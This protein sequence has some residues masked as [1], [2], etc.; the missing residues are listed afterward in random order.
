LKILG[1]V[2][3]VALI[4]SL[5]LANEATSVTAILSKSEVTVGEVFTIEL[6]ATGPEGTVWTFPETASNETVEVRPPVPD[7][8]A[9]SPASSPLPSNHR[10]YE[11]AG[12]GLGEVDLP[13][14]AVRY[15]LADGTEGEVKTAPVPLRIRSALPKDPEQRKLADIR[16]PLALAI[17]GVFWLGSGALALLLAGVAVWWLRRRRG[18]TPI[19]SAVPPVPPDVEAR[20][21][22]ERLARAGLLER[23]EYRP[24]YIALSEVAKRYLER[25]LE[26]PVL[27][28]TSSETVAFLRDHP[29]GRG[30]FSAVRDLTA[31]ADQVKFA[32]GASQ[33][34][35]AERHLKSARQLIDTLEQRL[36]PETAAPGGKVA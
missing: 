7:P 8:K 9:A 6:Q 3:A 32:R 17:G 34:E 35:E 13:P 16:E 27:E 33:T 29:H 1:G 24:F 12:F 21:A 18:A 14:I 36:R 10:R 20:E 19:I 23:A 30:L 5:A 2:P 26:A 28:M 4:A 25:R 31:A 15:R 22:L 11:A